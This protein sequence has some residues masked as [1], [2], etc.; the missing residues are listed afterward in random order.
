MLFRSGDV[1]TVDQ[2]GYVQITDRTK[3]LVKSGGEWISS[4]ALENAMMAHPAVKEAAVVAIPH[5]R[6]GERPLAVIVLQEGQHATAEE[7]RQFLAPRFLKWW[8]PEVLVFLDEIPK[9]STGKFLKKELRER[10]KDW[11]WEGYK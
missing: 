11:K 3:D 10:Y 5:P 4:L 9:T 7:I 1:A 2:E 6:W 8:L